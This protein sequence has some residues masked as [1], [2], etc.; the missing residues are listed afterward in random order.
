MASTSAAAVAKIAYICSDVVV[1]SQAR[2]ATVSPFAEEYR[3]LSRKTSHSPTF[4]SVPYAADPGAY[5][6]HHKSAGLLAFTTTADPRV[7]A[8][9]LP[10]LS[11]LVTVPVVLHIAVRGDLADVLPLR[12]AVPYFLHSTT[13]TQA[14]DNALVASRIARNEHRAVVHAFQVQGGDAP[15][16]ELAEDQIR[17]YLADSGRLSLDINGNGKPAL[18]NG[19]ANGHA[20]GQT[21]GQV[22]GHTNGYTNGHVNGHTNSTDGSEESSSGY[23]TPGSSVVSSL[24]IDDPTLSTLFEAYEA[25]SLSAVALVRRA[26]RPLLTNGLPDAHTV[27]FVLGQVP[28][29][30]LDGVS[31]VEVSLLNPLPPSKI[32]RA[33]PPSAK[34]VIVLEQLYKW[35]VKWTPL[36]LEVM[37]ALQYRDDLPSPVVQS[38]FLGDAS[39]I[40]QNDLLKFLQQD[41]PASSTQRL[42]IGKPLALTETPGNTIISVPQIPKHE[43][44]Y[45]K[46]LEHIFSEKLEIA[47]SPGLVETHGELATTPEFALGRVRKQLEER[48]KLVKAV[49]TLLEASSAIP[50]DLHALLSKWLLAKDDS[51]KSRTLGEQIVTALEVT[52]SLHSVI[53]TILAL[54]SHFPAVSRWIIGSDAW[55]YD[56]G[57]SGLHHLIAS[58]LNVNTL[59]L[60]TVP[61]SYR[62]STDQL[63]RKRDVGL[64]AMNHSDVYV[65]SVAVYSS[66]TQVLQALAEADRFQGPSV[67]LAYLP[68]QNEDTPALDVLKETKL[69]IDT[70]YWPLYR[71]DP[72]KEKAGGEPFS[73]DS[74]AVK[75]ELRDFLDRQNHL[76]QLTRSKPELATELVSSLGESVKEARR[77]RAQ[78]VYEDLLSNISGAP[79]LVLYASDGGA[80]EKKAK[81]LA[82]RGKARGLATTVATM[83]SMSIEELAKE[84]FVVFVTS[85]AGQGEAPQ[86]GRTFFKA[87]NLAVARSE[88][89]LTSV[90]YSVFGMGD[91]HYWP[92][93]EDAHYYNKSGKDL[94]ARISALGATRFADIGLGDDQD[95]D[96]SETGYKVWEPLVWKAIGV[97]SVEVTEAEPDPITNEH[98]KIASNFLRGTIAEGLT[99]TTTGAL[100][101][102]DT[103]LTKFHGIYQQDDRDIRDERQAQG[104][105]PAYS[106]MIRVRMPGGV[107]SPEQWL[108]MD[109]IA[110]E[111]GNGTFKITTRQTYQFHGVIKRHLKQSIRDI[112]R[113]LL[114]TLAAC[115]DVNRNVITS[116][117]PTKSQLHAEVYEFA[118]DVSERLLPRTSAYHEIWLDKKLVA[119]AAVHDFEPLYGEFYLPRKFKI[120]VAVPPTNDVDVFANDVGFIAIVGKDGKLEG[121]NVTA[122][123]G[124]GVTH[125]NKKTYPRLGSI[126]GFCTPTQGLDIAEKIMLVQRDNGNR[127]DRKN[128]RLKYTIDRMGLD[129]FKGEVEKLLGWTLAP[130]RTYTFDRNIDDFGWSTGQNGKHNFMMYIENGRVQNEPGREF[131]KGLREIAKV[132]KGSFRMTANQH[133]MLADVPSEDLPR[134][135]TLLSEYKLDNLDF[136]GLRLASSACV[137]FPTCGLAMAE[138]ERYLP[139]L[140]NK[141]EAICEENGLRN[142]SIVM[143]MTG[144]PNGCARPYVA[145]VAFVGK[146]PGTYLM[147]LGGGYYGQRLNKIYRE[148]VTE[149]EILAILRPMIKRYALERHDGEHFGDFVI[150]AGYISATTSG[151]EWYEGM[152]GLGPNREISAAA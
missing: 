73:L 65:A 146:A 149:P 71:W 86:N 102:S 33:I 55:S 123:G 88:T 137:A 57:A 99:D 82:N 121:F 152:G 118:K 10:H 135:K 103:Q 134:I 43:A 26:I 139:L 51:D 81:R 47:N 8:Q 87:L 69:A 3:S 67:I 128:A 7:L 93:P 141:V 13:P 9:L 53:P 45:I 122:G 151:K 63:R 50:S 115:G 83:D 48:E 85:V 31:W 18:P 70:G 105:E 22:N 143:R 66:Y 62:N 5:I 90:K 124:M 46:I 68:Y 41:P 4:V 36:Y 126:L 20:N 120:A 125:G 52:P 92:R 30:D 27:I 39:T 37:A 89:P 142:D 61:Y 140:I 84:E 35:N 34:R 29:L 64:Y 72:A 147:L 12:S 130:A 97:D 16:P 131:K 79:L 95:A 77:K 100:A 116:A 38:G 17:A 129:V 113:V 24:N 56:L 2:A 60:D 148:S 44:S 59:I 114:D 76:S 1:D 58:G 21:N 127:A 19:S 15:L 132:H 108:A 42:R 136:S 150:R 54:R 104:A 23:S 74:D 14:H 106:F 111:H 145:E 91:S 107:C 32:L 109:K 98:M 11:E 6:S 80:A 25:A 94:D 119:G 96:G 28:A 112:N 138:S 133:L 49:Q 117:I 101:P 40:T 110:D 75:Q 78:Q 144:C